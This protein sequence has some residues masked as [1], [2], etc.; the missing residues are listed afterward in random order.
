MALSSAFYNKLNDLSQR[1]GMN[2]RDLLLVMYSESGVS[3]GA[4]NPD[5]GAVGLIQFMPDTLKGLGVPA[6][7]V[8]HFGDK[9]P[10]E[11]L[12]YVERYIR[13][14]MPHSISGK[15]GSATEY[16]HANFFPITLKRWK[17]NDPVA[18]ANVVVVHGSSKNANER[19]AYKSN[20]RYF[21]PEHKGYITVGDL[22][23]KLM[24]RASESKF[25]QLLS[26][27]NIAA[28]QGEVSEVQNYNMPLAKKTDKKQ[29]VASVPSNTKN[30]TL[31]FL[32]KIEKFI[33]SIWRMANKQTVL[34]SLSCNDL[35]YSMEFARIL[36]LGIKEKLN[37]SADILYNNEKIELE[38]YSNLSNNN[39]YKFSSLVL[40]Q[41]YDNTLKI[42]NKISINISNNK[43]TLNKVNIKTADL[44]FR[45][46]KLK[47]IGK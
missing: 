32:G 26:Q 19:E 38:I 24:E 9:S 21:D 30:K 22:S 29:F 5:G 33:N 16:Y 36:S 43:S 37:C 7:E 6:S 41:F 20:W 3:S 14:Q 18:N 42:N 39:I 10:E 28:G 34:I 44:F 15:F 31:S 17:G 13:S 40:N 4:K 47:L 35:D 8:S 12:K 46:F 27:L 45:R 25:Q 23:K 2:P 11:Q 1:V